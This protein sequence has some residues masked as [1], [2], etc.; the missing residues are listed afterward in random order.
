MIV[1]WCGSHIKHIT[2]EECRDSVYAGACHGKLI[3][4]CTPQEFFIGEKQ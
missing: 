2:L 4:P 3:P 1:N